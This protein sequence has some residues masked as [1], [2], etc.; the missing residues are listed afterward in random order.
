LKIAFDEH[1]PPAVARVFLALAAERQLRRAT[2]NFTIHSARDYA[3]KPTDL[4]YVKGSDVPWVTR[5]ARDGVKVIISGDVNMRRLPHE[6]L[7][8]YQNNFIVFFFETQWNE[9]LFFRKSALLLFWWPKIVDKIR[10]GKPRTFWIIP[11]DWKIDGE[12]KDAS[13]GQIEM[14]KQKPEHN[15][16]PQRKRMSRPPPRSNLSD[17]PQGTFL[18][19]LEMQGGEPQEG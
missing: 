9:W 6:K 5:F 10:T 13:L 12:L 8:L 1:I 4:D 2:G 7:A 18:D 11:C 17:D 3:P 19:K 15:P 16:I 14:F